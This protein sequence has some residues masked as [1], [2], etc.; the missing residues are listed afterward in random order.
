MEEWRERKVDQ[1]VGKE[2]MRKSGRH[3]VETEGGQAEHVK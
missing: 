2:K 3:A 1:A